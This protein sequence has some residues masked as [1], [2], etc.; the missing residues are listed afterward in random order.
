[1]IIMG[2]VCALC[3][4]FTISIVFFQNKYYLTLAS[5]HFA[6]SLIVTTLSCIFTIFFDEAIEYSLL[7][8]TSAHIFA[9]AKEILI[10]LASTLIALYVILKLTDH[11]YNHHHYL[12]SRHFFAVLL[13]AYIGLLIC[14]LFTGFLYSIDENAVYNPV[15]IVIIRYVFIAIHIL[16]VVHCAVKN[17]KTV[18]KS[19]RLSSWQSL[20]SAIICGILRIVFP[21]ISF[22]TFAMTLLLTIFFLN[23]QSH[24]IGVNTLTSLNDKRRFFAEVENRFSLGNKF[25][26]YL[27]HIEN[28][29]VINSVYGHA[30]GDEVL[31]L[32]AFSLEKL[33]SNG[34][35][36]H[37]HSTTFALVLPSGE[38]DER[39][40]T[41]LLNMI[42]KEINC[43]SYKVKVQ[44]TMASKKCDKPMDVTVFYEQLSHTLRKARKTDKTYLA[45]DPEFGNDIRRENH[46]INRLQV[47]DRDH[48]YEVWYQPVWS[49]KQHR[50]TAMEAL[51]RLREP[52]GGFI[53]PA[54][55]IPI[56]EKTGHIT[57]LTWFVIGEV[58][59]TVK[60][61]T[62][63]GDMRVTINLSMSNIADDSF[64][65]A[66]IAKARG[67]SV[68]KSRISFEFTERVI[69][70]NLDAA[71]SN[72][73]R[74]VNEGF[75][76]YLDDFGVGYSN[77]NC[78]LNLPLKTIK[79]DMS[80]TSNDRQTRNNASMVS[81]LTDLFHDMGLNV[82]AEGAETKE[83]VETLI[84]DGVD[85]IQGYYFARPMPPEHLRKFL[86]QKHDFNI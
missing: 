21:R 45:Y 46:I 27:I 20:I 66:L 72:M 2:N 14:N 52:G 63:L 40:A 1:M 51:L 67:C 3:I 39:Q 36:F 74:L 83:Q 15:L 50:F 55:F 76:F 38:H 18:S 82:V 70:E 59:Q 7:D 86:E 19:A 73:L 37:L 4:L 60:E 54:E 85:G 65:D 11:T 71:A 23:F 79:L 53:S 5:K 49:T 9:F 43:S 81:V 80:I 75:S 69:R 31:Y 26:V 56:A 84:K 32:F 61:C 8:Q 42:K 12:N 16:T 78:I 25:N 10:I 29:D 17:A 64:V 41:K 33:F 77:F 47:I 58:C 28:Y 30:V 24:R 68:D 22:L 35:A 57:N 13:I 62:W 6:A 48:G 44:C 34:V